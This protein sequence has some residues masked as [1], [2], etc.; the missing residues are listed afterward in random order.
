MKHGVQRGTKYENITLINWKG[1]NAQHM[2]G[3]GEEVKRRRRQQALT[4]EEWEK[5]EQHL[6]RSRRR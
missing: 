3:F 5:R 1:A 6:L 2:E 4:W